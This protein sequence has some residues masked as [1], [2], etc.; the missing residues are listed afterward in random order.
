M[1]RFNSNPTS[2]KLPSVQ[3][4]QR[5]LREA[6]FVL[7]LTAQV[8]SEMLRDRPARSERPHPIHRTPCPH[9]GNAV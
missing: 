8:K 4:V 5:I 9:F 6:A 2:D 7:K 3:D 1:N